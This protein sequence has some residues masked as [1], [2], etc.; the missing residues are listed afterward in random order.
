MKNWQNKISL[1]RW[2]KCI[3]RGAGR[4]IFGIIKIK[5]IIALGMQE[6]CDISLKR[7]LL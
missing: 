6:T 5:I 2:K 4:G 1:Y 3:S 7:T